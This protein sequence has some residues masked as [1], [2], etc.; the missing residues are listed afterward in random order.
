MKSKVSLRRLSPLILFLLSRIA[1]V[2]GLYGVWVWFVND[3]KRDVTVYFSGES[4]L[5]LTPGEKDYIYLCSSGCTGFLGASKTYAYSYTA[6]TSSN[7]YD[8]T[9]SV[10][11]GSSITHNN[12]QRTEVMFLSYLQ[13]G[14]SIT[15]NGFD[16]NGEYDTKTLT[17]PGSC[18]DDVS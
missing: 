14:G 3:C 15:I 6:E 10:R 1:A 18:A 7:A 9:W 5:S 12:K 2:E 17:C 13:G 16:A 8:C 11:V 4:R